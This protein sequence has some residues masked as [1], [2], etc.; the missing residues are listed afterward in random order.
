MATYRRPLTS[1]WTVYLATWLYSFPNRG[2]SGDSCSRAPSRSDGLPPRFRASTTQAPNNMNGSFAKAPA[3]SCV[4]AALLTPFLCSWVN[5][6][7]QTSI[8]TVERSPMAPPPQEPST[9]VRAA[10]WAHRCTHCPARGF[11]ML[12]ASLQA[13]HTS[14]T[15]PPSP[16][17]KYQSF[18][19][20]SI[21]H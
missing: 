6:F 3:R 15:K 8:G 10:C 11:Q 13:P 19:T 2:A 16:T 9:A 17:P 14:L 7:F 5:D 1:A 21:K 20:Q 18:A 12:P 4:L